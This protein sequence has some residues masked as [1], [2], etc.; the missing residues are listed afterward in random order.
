MQ[1]RDKKILVTGGAGFLGSHLCRR[2]LECGA[3]VVLLDNTVERIAPNIKDFSEEVELFKGDILDTGIVDRAAAGVDAIIHTAFPTAGCDRSPDRQYVASGTEGTFNTLKAAWKNGAVFIYASSISVYGYQRYLPI[4]E[5]HPVQPF[6]LYGATKLAG[7]HYCRVMNQ[8]YGVK[9]LILRLSD[10]YGP[11]N[12][13]G[14]APNVFVENAFLGRPL[15]VR[16]G[17]AQMRTYTFIADAVEA[18]LL[19][20]DNQNAWGQTFN[21]GGAEC[22]SIGE[23]AERAARTAGSEINIFHENDAPDRRCYLISSEKAKK[24]LGYKPRVSIE[25]GLE[26]IKKDLVHK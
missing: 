3:K 25:R 9:T 21:I 22:I 24:V 14:S 19:A 10:L 4:D 11:G 1:L 20:I 15:V 26:S 5:K 2:L 13:R 16:G 6:L 18:F 8:E 12:G 17:G 7:E 23:L